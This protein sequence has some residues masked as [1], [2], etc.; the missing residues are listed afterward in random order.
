[1]YVYNLSPDGQRIAP[2]GLTRDSDKQ[3]VC[4]FLLRPTSAI[5][6]FQHIKE[7]QRLIEISGA[8][9]LKNLLYA[10]VFQQVS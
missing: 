6:M 3:Y 4:T 5:L 10:Q 9:I 8:K 7:H 2:A 1:M